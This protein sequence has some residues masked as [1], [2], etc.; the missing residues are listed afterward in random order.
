MRLILENGSDIQSRGMKKKTFSKEV[1]RQFHII[2]GEVIN[3]DFKLS[4]YELAHHMFSPISSTNMNGVIYTE[5][6]LLKLKSNGMLT[7]IDNLKSFNLFVTSKKNV[8]TNSPIHEFKVLQNAFKIK[9]QG[10][11]CF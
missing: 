8:T 10:L 11:K 7:Y 5:S 9:K 1:A 2:T 6:T 4:I 3:K